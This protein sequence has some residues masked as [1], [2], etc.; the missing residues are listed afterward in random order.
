MKNIYRVSAYIIGLLI[1]LISSFQVYA[2]ENERT[3]QGGG[4]AATGQLDN[5]SYTTIL[6]G[7]ENGLPT[8]DANCVLCAADGRMWIGGY[9]GVIVYDGVTFERL[10]SSGGA[11]S[12]RT[13]FE[14]K[15]GRIWVGTNDNG[16]VVL[17]GNEETRYTY[18]DGLPADSIRSFSEDKEGN[19]FAG[20]T[21]GIVYIDSAGKLH[22]LSHERL[23]EDIIEKLDADSNGRIYGLSAGGTI[24]SI[25]D[26]SVNN[27]YGSE[28]LGFK[29]KISAI[30]SDPGKDGYVYIGTDN[31]ELYYGAF[32]SRPGDMK[33][34]H[35]NGIFDVQWL[36]YE[37]NRVFVLSGTT[38]GYLDEAFSFHKLDSIK[39]DKRIEMMTSDYQGNLWFASSAQGVMKL[40]K[41]HFQDFN[42]S[43]DLEPEATNSVCEL[44]GRVY[45]GTENGLRIIGLNGRRMDTDLTR[46]IGNNR[47]RCIMKDSDD[48]LWISVYTGDVG[49]VCFSK[50]GDISAY[51]TVNGLP[52]NEIRCTSEMK[53]GSVIV[54]TNSGIAIIK[55]GKVTETVGSLQGMQNT[56]ILT[57]SEGDDG[58]IYAGSD[59]DG[60]YVI[61]GDKIEEV[62][63]AEGLTSEVILRIKKDEEHGVYWVITSNSIGYLEKGRVRTIKSFPYNNNYDIYCDKKGN[64]WILSSNGVYNVPEEEMFSDEVRDYRFYSLAD[65]LPYLFM[66]N[67]FSYMDDQGT[68]YAAGREGV[69]KF[70]TPVESEEKSEIKMDVSSV[71][72]SEAG[73]IRENDGVFNIPSEAGRIRIKASVMDYT[74]SDPKVRLF[75]QEL[76]DEGIT[77]T[78]SKLAPLEYTELPYGD[79][80]LYIQVLGE[81]GKDVLEEKTYLISKAPRI[82]ELLIVRILGVILFATIAGGLLWYFVNNTLVRKQYNR[83]L[84]AKEETD[85]ISALNLKLIDEVFHVLHTPVNNILGMDEMIMRED[86]SSVPVE[87]YSSI[88][89]HAQDIRFSSAIL[90]GLFDNL[91]EM[92]KIDSGKARISEND[93]A[94]SYLL[95]SAATMGRSICEVKGL[96]WEIIS[97]EMIPKTLYGDMTKIKNVVCNLI[98]V[99]TKHVN[100]GSVVLDISMKNRADNTCKL[101]FSVKITGDEVRA[102]Y[103]EESV[104]E[105][106]RDQT[107]IKGFTRTN[108][109]FGIIEKYSELLGGTVKNMEAHE[110]NKEFIFEISQRIVDAD[111]VGEYRE[112]VSENKKGLCEPLFISPDAGILVADEDPMEIKVIKGLVKATEIFVT[113]VNSGEECIYML[114][115][116]GFDMVFLDQMLPG[117]DVFETVREIKSIDPSIPVIVITAETSMSEEYFRS[118]GFDGVIHKP[119][120][121]ITLEKAIIRNIP[122]SKIKV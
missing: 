52:G 58:K 100:E 114:N 96:S 43:T 45:V 81:D 38:V 44:S 95:R 35:M 51:K 50:D 9:A 19:V 49:L 56:R 107:D 54:G 120:D 61:D 92:I 14:D 39:M 77:T 93:Y 111:P 31:G 62:G 26:C 1:I 82:W 105:D 57:V 110:K 17:H 101:C 83:V 59:G 65:G 7:A 66:Q 24:F 74:M 103:L 89:D 112:V 99:A 11:T 98:Y 121:G 69:I 37:C 27:I 33:K 87:Y 113:S 72:S 55:N 109:E 23:D 76:D 18:E 122:E 16:I 104:R 5:V 68:L 8:S 118:K 15:D 67:S 22:R 106:D 64:L 41:N 29:T 80:T 34:I 108:I 85:R 88:I 28:E 40:V 119:I 90:L 86:A 47:V 75:I 102:E 12:A 73:D 32:G 46:Y 6:Y 70:N 2:E 20:T 4:Y 117:M 63:K 13:L 10:D 79:Y 116:M 30:M 21:E 36:S 25:D 48:N 71:Y 91:F 94:F 42:Q 97:D 3:L 115:E 60:I 78:K 84:K 53:D